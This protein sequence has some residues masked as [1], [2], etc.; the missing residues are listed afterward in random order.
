MRAG[1]QDATLD[2][3]RRHL[4]KLVDQLE[5]TGPDVD[6]REVTTNDCRAFLD[7][8]Q[9]RAASTGGIDETML[10]YVRCPASG[11]LP[12]GHSNSRSTRT[13]FGA[14]PHPT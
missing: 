4:N 8:W 11:Y 14:F 12:P 5:R 13:G 2:S 1:R 3:Y 9:R 6:V 7:R 10:G